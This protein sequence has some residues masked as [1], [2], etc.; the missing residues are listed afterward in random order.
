MTPALAVAEPD[1]APR[2]GVAAAAALVAAL[3]GIALFTSLGLWQVERRAWKHDLIARVDA[4]IH[5]DAVA[6]PGPTEWA[7]VDRAG[8]EYR[9]VRLEGRFLPGRE[10][11]V[12]AL[13]RRGA[14]FWVLAPFRA[15]EGFT[16]LVNR[17]F[18]PG[19]ERERASRGTGGP[20]VVVGLL[21]ISEPEGGLL[22]RND[23]DA[24]RWYSRD[25][26]AIATARGLGTVAPYF[27]DAQTGDPD[28]PFAGL[29]VVSFPDNHAVY[30]ATWFA[31]AALLA[32][33]TAVLG[34]AAW[35]RR[36][37]G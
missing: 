14:G 6:A 8:D 9:R 29:T 4:R 21:R 26:A 23:P 10:T 1:A 34:R 36:H 17:G 13:T 22:R 16:V 12:Q 25:V 15:A 20:T 35:R 28:G 24:G 37:A 30:A 11:L 3:L 33:A 19:D 27:V 18:V 7:A 2:S 32:G 31:L 5:A